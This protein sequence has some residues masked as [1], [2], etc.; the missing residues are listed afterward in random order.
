MEKELNFD[1]IQIGKKI[2]WFLIMLICVEKK[3]TNLFQ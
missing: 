3:K 2:V 1:L